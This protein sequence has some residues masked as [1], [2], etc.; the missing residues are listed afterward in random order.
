MTSFSMKERTVERKSSCSAV[1]MSRM[2]LGAPLTGEDD[3]ATVTAI[4]SRYKGSVSRTTKLPVLLLQSHRSSACERSI[5][6]G[7]GAVS[8]SRTDDPEVGGDE[9][10][11]VD[12]LAAITGM[13]VRTTRY[14]A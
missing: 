5:V 4:L 6:E 7:G 8:A 9:S 14:Y 2:A 12:E 11:T 10:F 3:K 13:T 1:K